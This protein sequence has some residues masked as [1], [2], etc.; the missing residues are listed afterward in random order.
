MTKFL[1]SIGI[2]PLLIRRAFHELKSRLEFP[3][4]RNLKS[5]QYDKINVEILRDW[6]PLPDSPEVYSANIAVQFIEN[7]RVTRQVEFTVLLG[8]AKGDDLLQAITENPD[9]L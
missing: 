5:A 4:I 8:G 1:H 6:S 2:T 7:S 9:E 3:G